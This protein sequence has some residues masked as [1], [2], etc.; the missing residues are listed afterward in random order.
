MEDTAKGNPNDRWKEH[1][2]DFFPFC[3]GTR[4][5]ELEGPLPWSITMAVVAK[6]AKNLPRWWD[7]SSGQSFS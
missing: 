5:Q 6:V 3:K 2:Q 7:A 4:T 1:C